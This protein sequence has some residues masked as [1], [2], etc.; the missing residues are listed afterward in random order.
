MRRWMSAMKGMLAMAHVVAVGCRPAPVAVSAL[1]ELPLTMQLGIREW[2]KQRLEWIVI[3]MG[4]QPLIYF[5]IGTMDVS[6]MLDGPALDPASIVIGFEPVSTYA[7]SVP[8]ETEKLFDHYIH[9]PAGV[10]RWPGHELDWARMSW[11]GEEHPQKWG[12]F[13]DKNG[14][15]M[16]NA[17]IVRNSK[18]FYSPLSPEVPM[19]RIDSFVR[20]LIEPFCGPIGYSIELLKTDTDAGELDAILSAGELL[21]TKVRRVLLEA[22]LPSARLVRYDGATQ[23]RYFATDVAQSGEQRSGYVSENYL[24]ELLLF[25]DKPILPDYIK[26]LARYGFVEEKCFDF[27]RFRREPSAETDPQD[28]LYIQLNCVFVRPENLDPRVKQS[29][30]FGGPLRGGRWQAVCDKL[31]PSVPSDQVFEFLSLKTDW[32]LWAARKWTTRVCCG[33]D[34]RAD[35]ICFK[36]GL[37]DAAASKDYCCNWHKWYALD[38]LKY[39]CT[40]PGIRNQSNP[41]RPL[42]VCNHNKEDWYVQLPDALK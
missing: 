29:T 15:P 5:D 18:K 20:D 3:G 22:N 39:G 1:A 28:N 4:R 13:L 31:V 7:L 37:L 12:M 42:P 19:V 23:E 25:E 16:S 21:G 26:E 38:V 27:E 34:N 30:C 33:E 35:D 24:M 40:D 10:S 14:T 9:V 41:D 2:M 17:T 32:E 36:S 6:E 8:M 11:E